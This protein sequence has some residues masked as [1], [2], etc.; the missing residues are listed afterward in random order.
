VPFLLQL[1]KEITRET[2]SEYY[3]RIQ[4][5]KMVLSGRNGYEL[6]LVHTATMKIAD[7]RAPRLRAL[8]GARRGSFCVFQNASGY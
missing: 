5:E 7:M 2:E 8:R 1:V 6:C 4:I 3:S